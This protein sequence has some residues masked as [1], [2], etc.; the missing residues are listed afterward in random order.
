[1]FMKGMRIGDLC[2]ETGHFWWALKVWRWTM[3][4]IDAK[5]Y[6]DWIDVWFDGDRVSLKDVVSETEYEILSRRCSDLWRALGFPEYAWWDAEWEHLTSE[7][8][9]S[10]YGFLWAEK[11]DY[12]PLYLQMEWDEEMKD[13]KAEQDTQRLFREGQGDYLPSC[14]QDFTE[15]W[16]ENS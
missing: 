10:S 2:A 4:L 15:Y 12:Y 8:F 14:S 7:T 5:D 13:C 16:H 6:D 3:Q 11:Y 9:G 1:M